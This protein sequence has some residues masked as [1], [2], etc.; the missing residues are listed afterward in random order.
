MR[1][2][3]LLCMGVTVFIGGM[4]VALPE[5]SV[6]KVGFAGDDPV[7]IRL[8]GAAC[9]GFGVALLGGLGA[10]A[11]RLRIPFAS[12]AVL[13]IATIAVCLF[14]LVTGDG[15]PVIVAVLAT[16]ILSALGALYSL[17]VSTADADAT[18]VAEPPTAPYVLVL[19]VIGGVAAL[20]F[21]AGGALLGGAAGRLIGLN[22]TDDFI[23]RF[24]GAAPL[25]FLSQ[26][27]LDLRSGR[28]SQ[29]EIAF[30]GGAVVNA[31]SVVAVIAE[32]LPDGQPLITVLILAA[33]LFNTTVSSIALARRGS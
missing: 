23:Y 9:L 20:A 3:Q 22:G 10:P 12:V 29:M 8:A 31:F 24:A 4:L 11:A 2:F 25:G 7:V 1:I 32:L 19:N 13:S 18:A 16:A 14:T 28:W 33:A 30:L 6:Q 21:G 26:A 17:R 5:A 27:I 15:K